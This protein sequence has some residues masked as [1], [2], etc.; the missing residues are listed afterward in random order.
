MKPD[1]LKGIHLKYTGGD[2]WRPGIWKKW[3]GPLEIKGSSGDEGGDREEEGV[4]GLP[5]TEDL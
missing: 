2:N 3:G 4:E 5:G 1:C